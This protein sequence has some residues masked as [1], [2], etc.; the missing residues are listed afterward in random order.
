MVAISGIGQAFIGSC[1]ENMEGRSIIL[2]KIS[3]DQLGKE[4][5]ALRPSSGVI[6]LINSFSFDCKSCPNRIIGLPAEIR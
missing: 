6:G 4:Y 3:G 1:Y 5:D 2:K